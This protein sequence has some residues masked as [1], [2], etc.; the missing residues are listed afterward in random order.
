[1][2]PKVSSGQDLVRIHRAHLLLIHARASVGLG[3]L[4]WD[5]ALVVIHRSQARHRHRSTFELHLEVVLKGLMRNTSESRA[6][7]C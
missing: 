5:G 7:A 4:R 2:F 1:M 3:Q 6:A